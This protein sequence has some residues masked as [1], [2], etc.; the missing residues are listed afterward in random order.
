MSFNICVLASGSKGNAALISTDKT[1]ILLDAGISCRSI[2]Q[3]L[4]SVG[5]RA[6]ELDAVL[7][8]HCHWDH[9]SGIKTLVKKYDLNVYTYYQN[10]GRLVSILGSGK[11][12]IELD[13]NDFFIKEITVSPFE[14]MHDIHCFGYSFYS[15]GK[16]ITVMTDVGKITDYVRSRAKD[17]NILMIESN[18]DVQKL[19]SN[20]KYPQN[21]K[22]R[23]I[24]DQGHLSND[25]CADA[26]TQL[27]TEEG[28]QVVLAHLSQEN[29]TP[30][31]AYTI[32]ANALKNRG[33]EAGKDI[34]LCV[35]SQHKVSEILSVV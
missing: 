9:I 33:I 12:I 19:M 22:D 14:L 27:I 24:S 16:K 11:N 8:T 21:L 23:I 18:H 17:S 13:G 31:L 7:I 4:K 29:N 3:K 20:R 2:E 35:A 28:R 10:Y 30:E 26:L 25:L 34:K 6:Q 1:K 15:R 5:H 32:T